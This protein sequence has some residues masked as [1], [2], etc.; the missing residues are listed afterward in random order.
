MP[1]WKRVL[2]LLLSV[3]MASTLVPVTPGM[4]EE[5]TGKE[6]PDVVV[7][8]VPEEPQNDGA[9]PIDSASADDPDSATQG[10]DLPN[11]DGVVVQSGDLAEGEVQ[12]TLDDSQWWTSIDG[13]FTEGV[14][15]TTSE[16]TTPKVYFDLHDE[17]DEPFIQLVSSEEGIT[18]ITIPTTIRL[19]DQ[20]IKVREVDPST[21]SSTNDTLA[22]IDFY[23]NSELEMFSGAKYNQISTIALPLSVRRIGSDAFYSCSGLTEITLP[24]G[25]EQIEN[26]AFAQSAL[27]SISIP[28]TLGHVLLLRPQRFSYYLEHSRNGY[29]HWWKGLLRLHV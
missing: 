15:G 20:S 11:P 12:G 1:V 25:L 22:T 29:D 24:D 17:P 3:S 8:D 18:A 19:G 10:T 7:E 28:N 16:G 5:I 2:A 27:T 13:Y 6:G 4:A 23:S 26:N 14:T 9:T 21:F